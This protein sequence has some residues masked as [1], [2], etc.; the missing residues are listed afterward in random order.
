M[1]W[2]KNVASANAAFTR[3]GTGKSAGEKNS[4]KNG[5]KTAVKKK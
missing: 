5:K 1:G 4:G 2:P 3:C